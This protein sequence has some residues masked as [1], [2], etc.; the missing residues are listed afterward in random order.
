M[1]KP[2][3]AIEE[4][5]AIDKDIKLLKQTVTILEWDSNICMPYKAS[6]IRGKQL[7]I[8][9]KIIH[10]RIT[11]DRVAELIARCEPD[12]DVDKAF[13]DLMNR[14]H[15]INKALEQDFVSRLAEATQK[16]QQ[17]WGKAKEQS[18]YT[19]E[20]KNDLKTVV[21]LVR[22]KAE[23]IKEKAENLGPFPTRYDALIYEYEP[24]MNVEKL[25]DI[26]AKLKT[27]IKAIM[28]QIEDDHEKI[29]DSFFYKTEYSIERQEIFG[30]MVLENMGYSFARGR[31]DVFAHPFTESMG[32]HDVRITSLY[33]TRDLKTSILSTIHEG[34]HALY[35]LGIDLDLRN[36]ILGNGTSMGIHESQSRCWE[37][38]IGRSHE[39]WD[40]YYPK[41]TYLFPENLEDID[42]EK[43]YIALNK[44]QYSPIRVLA[45][46]VTYN[47]HIIFRYELEKELADSDEGSCAELIE[48][49]PERWNEKVRE[50]LDES[51]VPENDAE[52]VLQDIHWAVGSIGYFPTY[53]LGNLYA[54]QF[55][56]KMAANHPEI[57]DEVRRGNLAVVRN[58]QRDNIHKYGKV[59]SADELCK[60]VTG[61]SLQPKHL[62]DFLTKKYVNAAL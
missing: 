24:G 54:A 43:F 56:D 34:G 19:D 4:L 47:L 27:G 52:G 32:K 18:K 37:N 38:F 13:V 33:K 3:E 61:Q 59:Y 57:M 46:E 1:T 42:C 31:Q 7:G 48:N 2:N 8:L 39:F 44:A 40:F 21:S 26:F 62:I 17:S 51:A 6:E 10:S 28:G 35:E 25:D 45:D 12:T 22:E 16:S 49:L 30:H 29:D 50:I 23:L 36:T 15:I 60:R 41:L 5:K 11:S 53:T 14:D 20:Y 58:W 9:Q 55:L